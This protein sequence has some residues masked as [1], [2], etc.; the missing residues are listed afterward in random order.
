M[1]AA[2][3]DKPPISDPAV[4]R[5]MAIAFDLF[6]VA[7][8]MKRQNLRRQ[9]PSATEEEIEHGVREWLHKRPGA[10]HGDGVGRPVGLPRDGR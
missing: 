2:F 3:D 8:Q 1:T 6:E 10:E 5:R 7:V 9:I 4:L